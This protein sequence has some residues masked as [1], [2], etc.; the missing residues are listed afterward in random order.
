VAVGCGTFL[1]GLNRRKE[2]V[3]RGVVV[4]EVLGWDSEVAFDYSGCLREL[5]AERGCAS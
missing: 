4:E 5:R 3:A 1:G 2:L